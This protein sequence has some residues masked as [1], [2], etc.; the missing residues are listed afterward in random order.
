MRRIAPVPTHPRP[1]REPAHRPAPLRHRPAPPPHRAQRGRQP[2]HRPDPPVAHEPDRV[3][4]PR[5][6]EQP[7]LRFDPVRFRPAQ[8]AE[9]GPPEPEFPSRFDPRLG[10]PNLPAGRSRPFPQPPL[11]W[12][13]TVAGA[14][15]RPRD[16]EFGWE[17][18][19]RRDPRRSAQLVGYESEPEPERAGREA[20]GV[21]PPVVFYGAGSVP[22]PADRRDPTVHR[23]GVVH[24]PFGS[25]LQPFVR[26]D[27][28]RIAV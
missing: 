1:H 14:D 11:R 19:H 9:P 7:V 27:S 20:A 5:P 26:E 8:D 18:D 15:G 28:R 24:R 4:A 22:E 25:E 16:V 2:D 3:D 17:P 6:P 21:W 12:D 13:P 10:F 23:G